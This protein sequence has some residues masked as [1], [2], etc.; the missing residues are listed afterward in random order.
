MTSGSVP[1][2]PNGPHDD[3]IQCEHLYVSIQTIGGFLGWRRG[4]NDYARI[5]GVVDLVSI[6]GAV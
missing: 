3:L 2:C 1:S 5:H 4:C 6:R